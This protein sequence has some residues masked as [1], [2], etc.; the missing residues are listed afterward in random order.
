MVRGFASFAAHPRQNQI[1]VPPPLGMGEVTL[2][3]ERKTMYFISSKKGLLTF[4][5]PI[6]Q[7]IGL[8]FNLIKVKTF[9]SFFA[10]C[11]YRLSMLNNPIIKTMM[12]NPKQDIKITCMV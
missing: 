11:D 12:N 3:K 5:S 6:P 2:Y 1:R 7:I 4:E 9:S 10:P 8:N